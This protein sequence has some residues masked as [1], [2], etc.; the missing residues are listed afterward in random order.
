MCNAETATYTFDASGASFAWQVS[1]N[2]MKNSETG[3]SIIITP[4]PNATGAAYIK[5]II[6]GKE[7]TKKIWIGKPQVRYEITDVG[8]DTVNYELVSTVPN[9]SIEDQGV[10]A[11]CDLM[12]Y[13]ENGNLRG[14]CYKGRIKG[15]KRNSSITMETTV[16]NACEIVKTI[17][18]YKPAHQP[19]NGYSITQLSNE[20]YQLVSK[21]CEPAIQSHSMLNEAKVDNVQIVNAMGQTVLTTTDTTFSI[22]HLL[23]GTYYARVI[24]DGQ[25]VHTQTL[26]KK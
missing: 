24:K 6:D 12:P 9:V 14:D 4:K 25:V 7:I 15:I 13:A 22:N 19:C 26:I 5:A 11:T 18:Y 17:L 20:S 3:S 8:Y 10:N 16:S 23:S 1:D 21:P 2:L